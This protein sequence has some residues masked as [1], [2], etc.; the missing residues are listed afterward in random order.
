MDLFDVHDNNSREP[1][2]S[3]MR[4]RNLDEYIGQDH[5]VGKGRLL[6]RA[7]AADQLT[8][9]IFYGPPGTGKTT[10]ARVIANHTKSL[11]V[12][13]NAV[14]TGVQNIRDAIKTANEQNKL[15]NKRTILF[16][17]E[18]HRWNKSQQ[19]AL[20]PWV[21]NG[22]IILVGATTE[23]PFFEVNKALVSRS[24]VFQL[25]PLTNDDLFKA[26]RNALND[27]ERGYGNKNVKFEEGALEHLVNTANGDCRSLLN[28]LELAVETTEPVNSTVFISCKTA[29]E[30]IQKK[31]VLYDRDGDY[32]YDIISAFI[33]SLR[34]R[35]PDAAMYWMARMISA[36][37]DP[38]FI[39]RRM[40]ISACE[41]TGLAD[42]QAL[43]IV[44]NCAAAYDRIGMPE[45]RFMLTQAALYL[46]TAPKSN[47][48]LCYFDAAK[49]VKTENSEVPNHLKDKSRDSEQLGHGKGYMYPH[50][51]KD[52]WVAQQ[53]LPE[54]MNGRVFYNPSDQGYEAK[55]QE[56]V[57]S[58]RELQIAALL[59]STP[60]ESD[61]SKLQTISIPDAIEFHVSSTSPNWDNTFQKQTESQR[62]DTL[63]Q[64]RDTCLDL[65]DLQKSD[66]TLVLHADD[67]L[68]L[69][70]V[71]RK[72]CDGATVGVCNSTKGFKTL[73]QYASTLDNFDIPFIVNETSP[74]QSLSQ[75]LQNIPL[76]SEIQFDK[77]LCRNPIIV[78]EDI[79]KF[80][81]KI[82]SLYDSHLLT[83]ESHFVIAQDIPQYTQ[84][85]S[86]LIDKTDFLQEDRQFDKTTLR[87][88]TEIENKFYTNVENPRF[89]WN[90]QNLEKIIKEQIGDADKSIQT[91][92]LQIEKD[93]ILYA[94]EINR[95]LSS[96]SPY[97][98]YLLDNLG[99]K[100][101][102]S[103]KKRLLQKAKN[104]TFKWKTT[105]AIVST[106]RKTH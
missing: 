26:A 92:K 17:D 33:K 39:F 59:E 102:S 38:H 27:K 43:G 100:V 47:S 24:R 60:E 73:N 37:E 58:R 45:G 3:R 56:S 80:A 22:T 69:W 15:Y 9:V 82:Q 64:I 49:A 72:C 61:K 67:G 83:D 54:G 65:A 68:F 4:P 41:D 5:I 29:E 35:D 7:I 93:R 57:L 66:R 85:L 52:H 18:V 36:G 63:L 77:V 12:T 90:E 40:L 50:A 11:F 53:Y 89:N 2:A 62:T 46:A 95:W 16:V 96:K 51:Y 34:G 55:I 76:L 79:N 42:P 28:A 86:A 104:S 101:L 32:H 84:R 70:T 103:L 1:L 13:L 105:T 71:W 14:L 87:A 25:K 20:L 106:K 94:D 19:D 78:E 48:T 97:G 75:I 81:K 88:I 98:K 23:N 99:E 44:E 31:V 91:T 21:E 30:S 8:S 10:L 6:R 74:V